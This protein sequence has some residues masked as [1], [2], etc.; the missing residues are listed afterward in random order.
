MSTSKLQRYTGQELRRRFAK[1]GIVENT[2]P[3]W[4]IS[5]KGERLELDFYLERLGIAVEV[6]GRQHFEF[7]P[8]FHVSEWDFQEQVRRDREK[9]AICQRAGINLLYVCKRS[10]IELV[11]TA[12]YDALKPTSE[13]V[14]WEKRTPALLAN[15]IRESKDFKEKNKKAELERLLAKAKRKKY[16]QHQRIAK[17]ERLIAQAQ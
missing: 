13:P 14:Q 5:S 12:C 8:V 16:P 11:L 7:V 1:Y 6:Q 10:D 2:R 17:L 15:L 3:D 9:L 4:L